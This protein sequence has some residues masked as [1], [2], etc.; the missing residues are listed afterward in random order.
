MLTYGGS[1][2]LV[3]GTFDIDLS[4]AVSGTF[5]LSLSFLKGNA[6]TVRT[7]ADKTVGQLREAVAAKENIVRN[8]LSCVF[9]C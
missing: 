5:S 2:G 1:G 6:Y 4:G 8:A 3:A 9:A 7:T